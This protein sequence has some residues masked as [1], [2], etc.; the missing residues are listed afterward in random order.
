MI[1][2]EAPVAGM[3]RDLMT[4]LGL[5]VS[6]I[7]DAENAWRILA[8][9]RVDF[10]VITLDL[11]LSGL[12]GLVLFE[13]L[14]RDLPALAAR[15]IFITGDF[16]NPETEAFLVRSGHPRSG[17]RSARMR[18]SRAWRLCSRPSRS[19]PSVERGSAAYRSTAIAGAPG[20]WRARHSAGRS[21]SS[22]AASG[23]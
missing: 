20:V 15:V 2:D 17:S 5:E 9:D 21:G 10:D 4:E 22:M 8:E 16:A 11:R 18:S 12:S 19:R 23:G 13:R 7:A 6:V 1:E 14:E 3:L